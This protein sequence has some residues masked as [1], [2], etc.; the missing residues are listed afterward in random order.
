[1]LILE[2]WNEAKPIMKLIYEKGFRR[3]LKAVTKTAD[4]SGLPVGLKVRD[5]SSEEDAAGCLDAQSGK[6]AEE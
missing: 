5:E 4:H 1:M 6:F 2:T 3:M